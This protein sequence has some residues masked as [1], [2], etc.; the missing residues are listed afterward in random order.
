MPGEEAL[1][2][3]EIEAVLPKVLCPFSLI[4][5]HPHLESVAT[6]RNYV[7]LNGIGLAPLK[8]RA[9]LRSGGVLPPDA[10][11]DPQVAQKG[12]GGE[13]HQR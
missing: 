7:K 10:D 4:P 2:T 3:L 11:R 5:S 6:P 9:R 12:R 13:D 8:S 1:D